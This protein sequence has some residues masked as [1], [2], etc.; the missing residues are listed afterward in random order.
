MCYRGQHS[1]HHT[2]HGRTDAAGLPH[3]F[4]LDSKRLA[5]AATAGRG[6][7]W[8][9]SVLFS[10]SLIMGH[11]LNNV[12]KAAMQAATACVS[13]CGWQSMGVVL[14]HLWACTPAPAAYCD[15]GFHQARM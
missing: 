2:L 5:G 7:A 1:C 9:I 13:R 3:L 11:T 10:D 14:V 6:A 8:H 15:Y 4:Q 12:E